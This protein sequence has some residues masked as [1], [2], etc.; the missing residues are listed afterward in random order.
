MVIIKRRID[1]RNTRRRFG[2]SIL[3]FYLCEFQVGNPVQKVP[4]SRLVFQLICCVLRRLGC[5]GFLLLYEIYSRLGE[6]NMM[7]T[8]LALY[9]GLELV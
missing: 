1:Y 8:N 2:S 4:V 6:V 5:Q 3:L 9:R 7:D